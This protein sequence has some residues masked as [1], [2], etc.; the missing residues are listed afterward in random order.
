MSS[1]GTGPDFRCTLTIQLGSPRRENELTVYQG[2]LTANCGEGSATGV[3]FLTETGFGLAPLVIVGQASE[4]P[5]VAGPVY[6]CGWGSFPMLQGRR[7]TGDW[8]PS[9]TC[10]GLDGAGGPLTLTFEG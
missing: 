2:T 9:D 10:E 1:A 8:Q 3:A 4:M 5:G 6:S 7:L